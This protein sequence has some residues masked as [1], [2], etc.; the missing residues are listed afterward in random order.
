MLQRKVQCIVDKRENCEPKG[1]L[2]SSVTDLSSDTAAD[3][4][5][6][7][8]SSTGEAQPR[9]QGQTFCR[10]WQDEVIWRGEGRLMARRDNWSE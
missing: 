10:I 1:G 4:C 6:F 9:G 8:I 3:G 7:P 2:A 5:D